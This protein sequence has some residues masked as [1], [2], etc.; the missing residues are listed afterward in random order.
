MESFY[1]FPPTLVNQVQLSQ[2]PRY[3]SRL[4]R[5]QKNCNILLYCTTCWYNCYTLLWS[6]V[7]KMGEEQY[8]GFFN[9]L[10]ILLSNI[11]QQLILIYFFRLVH[12]VPGIVSRKYERHCSKKYKLLTFSELFQALSDLWLCY[13][14]C[15]T[16]PGWLIKFAEEYGACHVTISEYLHFIFNIEWWITGVW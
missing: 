12:L 2:D 7:V 6:K 9:I 8:L 4:I 14:R 3:P 1:N 16:V 10:P 13:C 15:C 5:V 11:L